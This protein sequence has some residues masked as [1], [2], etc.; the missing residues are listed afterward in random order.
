M[1]LEQHAIPSEVTTYEFRLVG[2]MTLKQFGWLAGGIM[3][4]VLMYV[5]DFVP[6]FIR[7]PVMIIFPLLGFAIA[8]VP[9]QGR[10]LDR[11]I[12]AFIKAI[13]SPTEFTW[14]K[15]LAIPTYL[16]SNRPVT[17]ATSSIQKNTLPQSQIQEYLETLTYQRH[18]A[19]PD[20]LESARI[21]TINHLLDPNSP[22][23]QAPIAAQSITPDV[24]PD[25][26][27][28]ESDPRLISK[29][30]VE[31]PLPPTQLP[32]HVQEPAMEIPISPLY[33]L[34]DTTSTQAETTPEPQ[35]EPQAP[36]PIPSPTPNLQPMQGSQPPI[37]PP[38]AQAM[39]STDQYPPA[40]PDTSITT[41]TSFTS[42]HLPPSPA[43]ANL[44]AGV[45]VD[46]QD[47][48]IP[49]AIVE[50]NTPDNHPVRAL[51]TNS[52]GQFAIATPLSPG[53]YLVTAEKNNSSTPALST[54]VTGSIIPP[55]TLVFNSGSLPS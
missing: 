53:S 13:Y 47:K 34:S 38:V 35:S 11:W 8:F 49:D 42:T 12:I 45:V 15:Q 44:L 55:V 23:S 50:I 26:P 29:V 16:Q 31:E 24:I 20:E 33:D 36:P 46:H 19:A 6:F 39:S 54:E 2:D 21:L 4:G 22:A 3:I 25:T 51:K 48:P 32:P 9:F 27:P 14:H 28:Q 5:A 37:E 43:A 17:L 7:Y 52:L 40:P 30:T 41:P 10:S 1:A 18:T